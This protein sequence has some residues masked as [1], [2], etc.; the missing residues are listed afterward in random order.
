MSTHRRFL[1]ALGATL[2][3]VVAGCS[4]GAWACGT[5]GTHTSFIRSGELAAQLARLD[6]R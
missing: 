3:L 2:T 6:Q 5:A 4:A 1:A